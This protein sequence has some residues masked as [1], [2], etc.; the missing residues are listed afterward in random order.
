MR[1]SSTELRARILKALR[2]AGHAGLADAQIAERVG[3][4]RQ[5]VSGVR[6][7]MCRDGLLRSVGMT[8]VTGRARYAQRWAL[9]ELVP[10]SAG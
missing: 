1:I 8:G 6:V 5:T 9:S 2:R 7:G 3:V 10:D 4:A